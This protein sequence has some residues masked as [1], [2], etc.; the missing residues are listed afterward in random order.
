MVYGSR[1]VSSRGAV[2]GRLPHVFDTASFQREAGVAPSS[3][4]RAL[5]A[6]AERGLVTKLKRATWRNLTVPAPAQCDVLVG[7]GAVRGMWS[8][9]VEA[10]LEATYGDAPRRMSGM[11]A[12]LA[13]GVPLMCGFEIAVEHGTRAG[14]GLGFAVRGEKPET[15]LLHAEQMTAGTWVSSP[16]RAVLECAQHPVRYDRWEERLGWMMVSGFDVCPPSDVLAVSADLGWRAGL[17][18]LSSIAEALA[19]SRIGMIHEFSPDPGWAALAP[20]AS[21]GDVWVDLAPLG[22]MAAPPAWEDAARK[23]AWGTTPDCLAAEV[24]T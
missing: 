21:Q 24:T 1:M 18:R 12:L 3:A 13:A 7:P 17:R 2:L 4:S 9:E 6:L 14:S 23:V 19:A 10:L 22:S 8:P 16:P 20:T 11:T 5:S 15:L